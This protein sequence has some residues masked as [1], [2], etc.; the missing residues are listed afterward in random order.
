M[1]K[2][3]STMNL[4]NATEHVPVLLWSALR[5][6]RSADKMSGIHKSLIAFYG[7]VAFVF[8]GR[9]TMQI[10]H[11]TCGDADRSSFQPSFNGPSMYYDPRSEEQ[12]C[13]EIIL[14]LIREDARKHDGHVSYSPK[15]CRWHWHIGHLEYQVLKCGLTATS[16]QVL[17]VL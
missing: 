4:T 6:V 14:D 12:T 16:G 15:P 13:Q 1:A 9:D 5:L 11:D 10:P 8:T 17:I 2:D 7:I 3:I